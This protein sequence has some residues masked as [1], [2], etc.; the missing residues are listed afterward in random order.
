[1]LV[2]DRCRPLVDRQC[3]I[4][5]QKSSTGNRMAPN[6]FESSGTT[7]GISPLSSKKTFVLPTP[8]L[9]DNKDNNLYSATTKTQLLLLT[10]AERDGNVL[11]IEG[12]ANNWYANNS[13]NTSLT[14]ALPSS[15]RSFHHLSLN[16]R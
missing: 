2:H 15:S 7:P 9:S 12:A 11:V 10:T 3:H 5:Q 13:D 6:P 4:E 14:F 1:M 16:T 8:R